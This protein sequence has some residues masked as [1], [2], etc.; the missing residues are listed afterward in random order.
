MSVNNARVRQIVDHAIAYARAGSTG[1]CGAV[2]QAWINLK[3]WRDQPPAPGATP[4][5]LD[6]EVA[7]AENYM[8]ARAT[9]CSGFVSRFQMNSM[10]IAY[11]ASKRFVRMPTSGNPQSAPDL[12]V[13][14]WGGIGSEE[15]EA[16]RLRCNSAVSPPVW[17]S[18]NEVMP[19]SGYTGY[20]GRPGTSGYAPPS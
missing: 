1:C 17:R 15:G 9:V 10:A 18:P 13:L 19:L 20:V 11:Y 8:Y 6:L 12:G 5:S 7:A 14:G 16:D 4:N 2:Q 3:A